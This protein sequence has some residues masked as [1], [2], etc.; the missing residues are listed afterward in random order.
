[1]EEK[2]KTVDIYDRVLKRRGLDTTYKENR[3]NL[4]N[5]FNYLMEHILF[6]DKL[7]Y[8]TERKVNISRQ[9]APIIE[10]MLF[11]ASSGLEEH[12]L[13][14]KWFNGRIK[15]TDYQKIVEL[16]SQVCTVLH[17]RRQ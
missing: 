10:E 7:D 13:F 3:R 17:R 1:M 14:V 15:P 16:N 5:K 4:Q 2:F 9:E 12:E 11:R 8:G 6:R